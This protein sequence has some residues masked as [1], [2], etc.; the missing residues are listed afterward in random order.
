MGYPG[1]SPPGL[2]GFVHP[3]GASPSASSSGTWSGRIVSMSQ[4]VLGRRDDKIALDP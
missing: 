1:A 2:G 3:A 4:M